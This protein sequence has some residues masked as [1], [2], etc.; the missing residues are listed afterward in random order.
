MASGSHA[1]CPSPETAYSNAPR[2]LREIAWVTGATA[3]KAF[4]VPMGRAFWLRK[5]AVLDRVALAEEETYAPEVAAP[6]VETAEEAA[7]QLADF[8]H[9]HYTTRGPIKPLLNPPG[10]SYRPY[11]RQEYLAW[12]KSRTDS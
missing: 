11:V 1:A 6:A 12:L 4:G 10:R 3:D 5:A 8:D 7:G 9:T 2:I